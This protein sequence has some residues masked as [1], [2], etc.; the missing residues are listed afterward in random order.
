MNAKTSDIPFILIPEYAQSNTPLKTSTKK[1]AFE[2]I[3]ANVKMTRF[4]YFHTNHFA[5]SA[6]V[7]LLTAVLEM[8]R[9]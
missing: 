2:K 1:K 8:A 5:R 4:L 3:G 9:C 6:T 7:L